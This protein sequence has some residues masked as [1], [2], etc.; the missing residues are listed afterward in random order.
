MIE[1]QALCVLLQDRYAGW[2]KPPSQA[3]LK[4]KQALKEIAPYIHTKACL[5]KVGTGFGIKTCVKTK[6]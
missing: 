4:G 2:N 6:R 5:P 3:M 1:D